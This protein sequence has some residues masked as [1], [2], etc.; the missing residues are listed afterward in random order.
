MTFPADGTNFV[1][2]G[3][4]QP[5]SVHCFDRTY[6]WKRELEEMRKIS[7]RT[8]NVRNGNRM[9][10]ICLRTEKVLLK[11]AATDLLVSVLWAFLTISLCLSIYTRS[12]TEHEYVRIGS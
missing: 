8:C 1:F 10:H 4:E 5:A 12:V 6:N 9:T 3:A 2:Y 7:T 11:E